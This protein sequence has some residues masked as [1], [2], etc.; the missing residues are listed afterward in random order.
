MPSDPQYPRRDI[1]IEASRYDAF[2]DGFHD[3]IFIEI[4]G[5]VCPDSVP[6]YKPRIQLRVRDAFANDARFGIAKENKIAST[7]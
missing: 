2:A 5:G 1:A 7:T 4:N 6:V 3:K